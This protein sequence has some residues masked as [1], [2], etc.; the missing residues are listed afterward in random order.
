MTIT[1]YSKNDHIQEKLPMA[2]KDAAGEKLKQSGYQRNEYETSWE[3][4]NNVQ[5]DK[6]TLT[7]PGC[8]L[9]GF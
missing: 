1:P 7:T 5:Y 2:I 3:T 4:K 8:S 6:A 9:K